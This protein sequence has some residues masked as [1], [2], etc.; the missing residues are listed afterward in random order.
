MNGKKCKVL[1][2]IIKKSPFSIFFR[3]PVDPIRDG[4][5]TYLD[6]IK[7][8]MDLSTMEKKVNQAAYST[9]GEFASDVQ[10]IFANCRQFNPPGTEPCQHADELEKMWR[11]EWAKTVTPKLEA[12]EKRALVALVNRLKTH[13]SSILFREPVDP[14]AL[15]IPTYFDII[16]RKDARDLSLIEAKLKADKYESFAAFDA[17]VKLM[18]RTATRSISST[19]RS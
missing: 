1:L 6:E 2:Q 5:P 10:L 4:L 19:R 17:D 3:F 12:N 11:K 8:P 15:G 14:V 13:Q 7:E 16:P 9:M 18:L